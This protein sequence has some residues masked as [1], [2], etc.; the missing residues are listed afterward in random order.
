M[1]PIPEDALPGDPRWEVAFLELAHGLVKAGARSKIIA[2]LTELPAH[3]I[4]RMYRAL[5]GLPAPAGAILQANARSFAMLG[6][7]TSASWSV[8][9]AIL[10]ACYERMGRLIERPI[11]RGW[12]LLHAFNA[13]LSLTEKVHAETPSK[14][15]DINQAYALLTHCGF[16]SPARNAELQRRQCPICLIRYPVVTSKPLQ[17]Q[18]CPVC[19]VNANALRLSGRGS[20]P[21]RRMTRRRA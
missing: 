14:R 21:A 10:L 3:R 5:M 7:H 20:R 19:L 4:R 15:L 18:H 11:H 16:L 2:H 13:Y 8:Q 1:G 9:V 12:L 17:G 6:K